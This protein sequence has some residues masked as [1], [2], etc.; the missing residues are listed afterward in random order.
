MSMK[1]LI[2]TFTIIFAV[3]INLGCTNNQRKQEAIL[4]QNKSLLSD[5]INQFSSDSI[6]TK[7][8]RLAINEYIQYIDSLNFKTPIEDLISV[9][10]FYSKSNGEYLLM[11]AEPYYT[12]EYI[13][14]YTYIG[15]CIFVYYGMEDIH[16]NTSTQINSFLIGIQYPVFVHTRTFQE[17]I[18]MHSEQFI[19]SSVRIALYWSRKGCFKNYATK[20]EIHESPDKN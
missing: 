1:I 9:L 4:K 5:T 7:P 18:V 3:L 6:F 14:G 20:L 12:K 2:T 16:R 10:Y 19:K 11:T 13:K 15:K 8:I 17:V